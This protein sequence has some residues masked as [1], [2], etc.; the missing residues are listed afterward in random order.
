MSLSARLSL[1]AGAALSLGSPALGGS[2]K[3]PPPVCPNGHFVVE[4]QPAAHVIRQPIDVNTYCPEPTK[5]ALNDNLTLT[6]NNAPT[7]IKTQV[8]CVE[9]VYTTY[10]R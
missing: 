9:T 5:I 7:S 6:V 3:S 2:L 8:T 4:L 10:T 1:I